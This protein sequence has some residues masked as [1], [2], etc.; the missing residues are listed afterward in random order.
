M[1]RYATDQRFCYASLGSR[2]GRRRFRWVR[3]PRG[4]KYNYAGAKGCSQLES[5]GRVG[6]SSASALQRAASPAQRWM[7]RAL[8]D[9]STRLERGEQANETG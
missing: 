6:R 1:E 4:R 5:T 8:R 3:R 7:E 9:K 2:E